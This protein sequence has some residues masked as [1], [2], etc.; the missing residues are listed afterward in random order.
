MSD[1][2]KM[3]DREKFAVVLRYQGALAVES[4]LAELASKEGDEA[5]ARVAQNLTSA[6]VAQ[7]TSEADVVSPSLLHT[8]VSTE[9]FGG[10][11]RRVG[12]KW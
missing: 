12:I 10:V 7:V 8:A 2:Q 9:Q 5:V 1:E 11:F 3:N 4:Q 6:E